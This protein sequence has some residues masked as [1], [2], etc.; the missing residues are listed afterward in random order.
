MKQQRRTRS[1]L[2]LVCLPALLVGCGGE[3]GGDGD[4]PEEQAHT[5]VF[6]SLIVPATATEAVS[7]YG[8]DID[9]KEND[10]DRGVDNQ[11]GRTFVTLSGTADVGAA[12]EAGVDSGSII[13]LMDV[14]TPD[15]TADARVDVGMYLGDNPV[16]A[17]CENDQDETCRRHLDGSASFELAPNTP[18]DT[19]LTGS[20][21]GGGFTMSAE[22]EPGRVAIPFPALDGGEPVLVE[23]VG[24]RI[25][26]QSVTETG[27]S[28][29][30]LG[31]AI[32][33]DDFENTVLPS[34]H[35]GLA[36]QVAADCTGT[37]PTCCTPDSAGEG[38]LDFFDP[39]SD[40]C[41]VSFE[42]FRGNVFLS[43]LLNPDVDLFDADG[44]YNPNSDGV[45]DSLS[46]G[47]GFSAVTAT[48]PA[49]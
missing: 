13:L 46:L 36:A 14:R 30:I 26:I 10:A 47:M 42:E 7:T 19:V 3:G 31:G 4:P 20:L 11:L 12:V 6:D 32:P 40:D 24:A 43:L 49:P 34:F 44:N 2:V 48:F 39:G 45:N 9:G 38:I 35:Q 27:L 5:F 22:D 23:L 15:L 17:A 18:T 8:L 41:M 1:A 21:A 29:G 37:A 25:S 33:A 28:T 16:P